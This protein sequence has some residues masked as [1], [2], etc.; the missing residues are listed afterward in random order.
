MKTNR[1]IAAIVI[2]MLATG[3]NQKATNQMDEKQVENNYPS[4]NAALDYVKANL[5]LILNE[6][7]IKS[8][9]LGS[10]EEIQK[11]VVT[12]D[13]PLLLLPMDQLKDTI[14]R[15][16][17]EARIYALGEDRNP[18]ICVVV[19]NPDGKNWMVS[20][21]GL[22][23]YIQSMAGQQDVTAIVDVLGLEISL[24]EIQSGNKK[25]Y[26]PIADYPEAGLYEQTA[27]DVKEVMRNLEAYRMELEKKFGK[28]F[29]S[30]ALDK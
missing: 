6:S 14:I 8:Y 26:M 29:S 28:E 2:L 17:S 15:S 18:K 7:Q 21:I 27:Y 16:V 9:N 12:H 20:T 23:K 5:H 11:L 3:C 19:K 22:M 10:K 4:A 1:F 24:L 30:G 25:V 13:L